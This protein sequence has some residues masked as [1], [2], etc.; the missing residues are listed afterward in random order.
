VAEAS[1]FTSAGE[2]SQL[3]L[4]EDIIAMVDEDLL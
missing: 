1:G 2:P 4:G 3:A